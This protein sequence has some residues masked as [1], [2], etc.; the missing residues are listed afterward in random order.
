[1]IGD[2]RRDTALHATPRGVRTA[3]QSTRCARRHPPPAP[4]PPAMPRPCKKWQTSGCSVSAGAPPRT[5][6]RRRQGPVQLQRVSCESQ[7]RRVAVSGCLSPS[8]PRAARGQVT[9]RG[10]HAVCP[11]GGLGRTQVPKPGLPFTALPLRSFAQRGPAASLVRS[12][13]PCG[14]APR[15]RPE[16]PAGQVGTSG[17]PPGLWPQRT[18]SRP[19]GGLSSHISTL[20]GG[21][22][23]VLSSGALLMSRE[24]LAPD[25][26]AG[27]LVRHSDLHPSG[28]GA[29]QARQGSR[30]R[31][32]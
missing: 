18:P 2:G 31:R 25:H 10:V 16:S 17:L 28:R 26:V 15:F 32:L 24:T 1:M 23:T 29:G 3:G 21:S 19:A 11:G 9:P 7:V 14:P 30:P 8:G 27:R 13:L 22:G 20:G 5:Q 6:Q 4:P 12:R